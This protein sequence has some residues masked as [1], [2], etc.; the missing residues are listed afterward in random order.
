MDLLGNSW[1]E[2][3]TCSGQLER[4]SPLQVGEVGW[5]D[6]VAP[7]PDFQG[8]LY[9]FL[10]GLL[11]TAYAP[12][13]VQQWR[14]RYANPPNRAELEAAFA[15]CRQAFMLEGDGPAF[16]QDLGLPDEANQLP[17][18]EL[19][20][21][22]GSS[23]NQY[24]NKPAANH[25]LCECCFAQALLTLQLN[26]PAGGRGV[27][28]SLRGGGPLT[29]LLLPVDQ[30]ATLWQKLWLNVLPQ[31]ALDYP[32]VAVLSDVLPW[33]ARTRTSDDKG[34]QDTPPESVHP[35]QAYWSMPRRI[36]LDASTVG[37]GQC[38]VCGASDVRL[39][40]HYRTRHGGTN[41]SGNWMHPLTP[42]SLDAKG[43]KP[44]ISCKG[45]QAGR[46][47]RDWLG[48][49]LGND[50]H[51]PDAAKV[52][53]HFTS[54]LNKPKAR[55]WC[56]GFS[57]SNMK[58]LCWY[59]STLPVHAVEPDVQRAFTK[60]VKRVLDSAESMASV[61]HRQVKAAW[62]RRPGDVGAE[63]AVLQSFWQGTET[64]FYHLLDELAVLDFDSEAALALVYRRWLL[65]T[66]RQVLALFDHWVLSGPLEDQDMQRVVKARAD[67]I[68][69]LNGGKALKPLWEIVN[70]HHKESA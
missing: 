68:K 44:P 51:Q 10:I 50:E 7:R 64:V 28:T 22:A 27:R 30:H 54:K 69:E 57:M 24:F 25:G 4:L 55:L 39:I 38:A 8:A 6:L 32:P 59:D 34:G 2:G 61:L 49:V 48:L 58:A 33:L 63:P 42:Y 52:V 15:L 11:Q 70:R 35:L 31:D 62:F 65:N 14:E 13:D 26:A 60:A 43:E 3:R 40:H 45:H 5:G 20:I 9:Q 56:F 16:M 47:Y 41:Y 23:S 37:H 12:L 67:L 36:R 1:L 46:G 19:L 21:D 66:R 17:V 53:A 18:L 29:T